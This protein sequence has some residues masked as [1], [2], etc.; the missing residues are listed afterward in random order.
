MS[1][2]NITSPTGSIL[3]CK[4]WQIEAPFRMIQNNLDPD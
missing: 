4:N 3:S 2:R 1:K